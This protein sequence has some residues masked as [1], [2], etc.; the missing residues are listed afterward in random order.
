MSMICDI[1][2]RERDNIDC[3]HCALRSPVKLQTFSVNSEML[4]GNRIEYLKFLIHVCK[5]LRSAHSVTN[6]GGGCNDV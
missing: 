1:I 4:S 5:R 3:T 6:D 2:N